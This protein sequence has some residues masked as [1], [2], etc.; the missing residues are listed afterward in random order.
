VVLQLEK[1]LQNEL[2]AIFHHCWCASVA[3]V[4]TEC[5]VVQHCVQIERT[6]RCVSHKPD[7]AAA[8]FALGFACM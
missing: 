7:P 4:T 6:R 2:S 1:L 3:F 5:W 8:A